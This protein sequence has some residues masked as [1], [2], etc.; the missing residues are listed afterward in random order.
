MGRPEKLT[1]I[2]SER[3][4]Q[5][6]RAGAPAAVA[7]RWAGISEASFY[8]YMA[9]RTPEH[10]A[11]R[12]KVNK[13]RNELELRLIGVITREAGTKPRWAL[14]LLARRFPMRWGRGGG[15]ADQELTVVRPD[16][17]DELVSLDPAL[18][19]TLVP[20]LLEAERRRRADASAVVDIS[21]FE[22]RRS[23]SKMDQD[24]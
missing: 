12:D 14:E 17:E 23:R 20:R 3:F 24:P 18:V 9:G 1:P 13:A 6:T 2:V 7:A 4:L 11:F 15:A 10:A 19:E 16:H 22:E 5:A 8:R 21:G